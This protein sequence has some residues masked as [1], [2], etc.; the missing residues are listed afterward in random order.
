[1]IIKERIAFPVHA[2]KVTAAAA[3]G[4]SMSRVLA[5]V[6]KI[7]VEKAVNNKVL[8]WMGWRNQFVQ[9]LVHLSCSTYS[10]LGVHRLLSK[11]RFPVNSRRPYRNLD[12]R[13]QSSYSETKTIFRSK[14]KRRCLCLTCICFKK[15]P[16]N[17]VDTYPTKFNVK[18]IEASKLSENLV[19]QQH[20]K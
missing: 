7:F 15:M 9:Q 10:D 3:L 5:C 14:Y 20:N 1:M 13:K 11:T 19:T 18:C 4:S 8:F 17:L 16:R 12:S 2:Q 6:K